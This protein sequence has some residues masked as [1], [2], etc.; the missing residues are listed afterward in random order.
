MNLQHIA[1]TWSGLAQEQRLPRLQTARLRRESRPIQDPETAWES[2]LSYQP[3]EGW[4]QFQSQVIAFNAATPRAQHTD[5]GLLLAAEAVTSDGRSL[6]VRQD[7][8]GGLLLVIANPGA[9]DGA[10]EFLADQVSQLATG[11]VAQLQGVASP[12][13]LHYRRYWDHDELLGF[14]PVFAAFLGFAKP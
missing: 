2:F 11:H 6:L 13:R 1:D 8:S 12:A 10:K 7:G 14:V 3:R 9:C 5:W 4:V